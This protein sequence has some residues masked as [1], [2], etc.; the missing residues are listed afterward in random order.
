MF[1]RSGKFESTSFFG[2][3][4]SH[5]TGDSSTSGVTSSD[6][7]ATQGS[8]TLDGYTLQL[9]FDDGTVAERFCHPCGDDDDAMLMINES[10]YLFKGR[11]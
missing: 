11:K 2:A 9:T 4:F 1:T 5:E 10:P 7:P 3:S 6:Q 8:Y